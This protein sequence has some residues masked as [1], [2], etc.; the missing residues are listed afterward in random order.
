MENNNTTNKQWDQKPEQ[1]KIYTANQ[2]W[3]EIVRPTMMHSATSQS[4]QHK[5]DVI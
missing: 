4:Q 5:N 3:G 2:D 1:T